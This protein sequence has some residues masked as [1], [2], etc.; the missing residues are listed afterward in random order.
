[1]AQLRYTRDICIVFHRL[2][3]LDGSVYLSSEIFKSTLLDV[4]Y[5]G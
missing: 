3:G 1:M 2:R 5:V 4:V